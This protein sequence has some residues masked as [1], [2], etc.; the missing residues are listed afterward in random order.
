MLVAKIGSLI[1]TTSKKMHKDKAMMRKTLQ[2]LPMLHR[3][4]KILMLLTTSIKHR[5]MMLNK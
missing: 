2:W 3:M 5:K 1:A 4:H